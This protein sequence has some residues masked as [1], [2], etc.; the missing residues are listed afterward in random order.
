MLASAGSPLYA[1]TR[2]S[3]RGAQAETRLFQA[4]TDV[5]QASQRQAPETSPSKSRRQR[6]D[7]PRSAVLV[8]LAQLFTCPAE[9]G[10]RRWH[11]EGKRPRIMRRSDV[12]CARR[13]AY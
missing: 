6:S 11:P 1:T 8:H 2:L 3:T 5:L 7:T 9:G 12:G 13:V 4:F 10:P